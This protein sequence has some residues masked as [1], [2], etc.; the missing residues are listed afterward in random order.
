MS[1]NVRIQ[2]I[3][4]NTNKSL[5]SELLKIFGIGKSRAL[6]ICNHLKNKHIRVNE[7][8]SDQVSKVEKYIE[9]FMVGRDL[10]NELKNIHKIMLMTKVRRATRKQKGLPVNGQNTKTNGK[11][12]KKINKSLVGGSK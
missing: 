12:A 8:T 6:E 5:F 4:F 10:K 1:I 9:Q 3:N 11:T 2:N 7:L